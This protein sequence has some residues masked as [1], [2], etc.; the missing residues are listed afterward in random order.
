MF[1]VFWQSLRDVFD[2]M[3]LLIL[4]NLVWCV[5]TLPLLGLAL[6]SL[7]NLFIVPATVLAVL[8][9]LPLGPA[10]AGLYTIAQRTTEGRTSKISDFIAGM[11]QHARFS[12]QV[13][14]VWMVG[15]IIII[16]NLGFYSSMSNA[17]SSFLFILVL[18]VLAIWF[19]LLIYIGP[20]MLLQTDKRILLLARNAA[21]MV[22][23][24]PV[25]TLVTFVLMVVLTLLAF[26][27]TVAVLP[28]LI[29]FSL[30]AVWSFRA[31]TKLVEDADERRRLAEEKAAGATDGVR[32]SKEKGRGGQIRPRE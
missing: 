10:T 21:L 19:A 8:A 20:L 32:Y 11:R 4:T 5:L 17:I 28:C 1:R 9:I 30:L 7:L 6:F 14:G 24:R 13:Y 15:L 18:Y 27:L 26:G 23:G 22:F 12:W 31:T 2:E 29:L 3:F 16:Y 25:F